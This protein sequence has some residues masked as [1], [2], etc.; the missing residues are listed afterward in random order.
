MVQRRRCVLAW[1]SKKED[2]AALG[3]FVC[4]QHL[5]MD[6]SCVAWN[7]SFTACRE[8]LASI[9]KLYTAKRVSLKRA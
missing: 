9:A 2:E 7:L 6:P 8:F 5:R 3:G 1:E 4:A